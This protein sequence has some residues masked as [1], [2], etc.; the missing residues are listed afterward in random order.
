MAKGQANWDA[1]K[2]ETFNTMVEGVLEYASKNDIPAVVTEGAMRD[3]LAQI[4][5]SR[6][7]ASLRRQGA[8]MI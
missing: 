5:A 6:L 4:E 1:K 7:L 8:K 3:I 2:I